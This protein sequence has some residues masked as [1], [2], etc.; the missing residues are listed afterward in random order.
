M[1]LLNTKHNEKT[2]NLKE[3]EG[4]LNHSPVS[5]KYKVTENL[6]LTLV[7]TNVK[8]FSFSQ[9]NTPKTPQDNPI[10]KR[11]QTKLGSKKV[12]EEIVIEGFSVYKIC[13]QI[14]ILHKLYHLPP[15]IS[16]NAG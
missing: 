13:R 4:D 12:K 3:R 9:K 8:P 10:F 6:S 16:D 2:K 1:R 7:P 11:T 15:S 14:K 5:C